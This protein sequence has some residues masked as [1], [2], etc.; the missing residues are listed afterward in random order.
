MSVLDVRT[1]A[2]LSYRRRSTDHQRKVPL[3]YNADSG[4]VGVKVLLR[5]LCCVGFPALVGLLSALIAALGASLV[6]LFILTEATDRF[7]IALLILGFE[8]GQ[9]H[10]R[11][12]FLLLLPDSL[13]F[14]HHLLLLP[15]GN[16]THDVA[17]LMDQTA[18]TQR[19]GK[20]AL[21]GCEQPFIPISDDQ[22]DLVHSTGT[23]VLQ[24][25]TPTI[26]A[27]FATCPEGQH[28]SAPFQIHPQR[29]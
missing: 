18:L 8:G 4:C 25:S 6:M 29:S 2:L 24:E 20:E 15:F 14:S 23:Q 12:F 7:G 28:F 21:H 19:R 3:C 17:L 11:I 16:S 10:K 9:I 22:I 13:E 26:L 1:G 5:R 27:L